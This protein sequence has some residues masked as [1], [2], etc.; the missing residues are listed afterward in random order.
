MT[1]KAENIY[2][3]IE[4]R[5]ETMEN[6]NSILQREEYKFSDWEDDAKNLLTTMLHFDLISSKDFEE[7]WSQMCD[8]GLSRHYHI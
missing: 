2:N 7:L 5:L 6:V 1:K 8:L 4:K 3:K